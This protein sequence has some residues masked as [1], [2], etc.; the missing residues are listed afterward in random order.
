MT[1]N[2]KKDLLNYITE[3]IPEEPSPDP[4]FTSVEQVPRSKWLPF[5]P[6]SWSEFRFEGA[7][8]SNTSDKMIFY[9]GYVEGGGTYSANSKGIIIITDSELNPIKTIY[10]YSSGTDLRP[11]YCMIQEEDGQFVAVDSTVLH[12]YGSTASKQAYYN[13]QRRFIMLNDI[14]I[15]VDNEY[16]VNLRTSYNFGSNYNNFICKDMYKNPS[17]S[18]YFMAGTSID[19]SSSNYSPRYTK[20]IDLKV[21]V[22]SSNEWSTSRTSTEYVYGG[23]YCYFDNNDN[24]QW[25]LLVSPNSWTDNT[26]RYWFGTNGSATNSW[27]IFTLNY[28]T[29]IDGEHLECQSVFINE[30]LVYFTTNNQLWGVSGRLDTKY[31]GLYEY[32]FSTGTLKEIYLKSLGNYDFS[33]LDLIQL[34]AVN[35]ELYIEH[36]DP[37]NTTEYHN[38]YYTV[39]RYEGEWNPTTVGVLVNYVMDRRTFY[40]SQTFNITK[41]YCLSTNPQTRGFPLIEVTDIYNIANYNGNQYDSY[42]SL[43][44]KYVDILAN[45]KIVFSRNLHNISTINNYTIASVE[46]PNTYLNNINLGPST[47][48]G[49]TGVPFLEDNTIFSKN[50]YETVYL[51]YINTINVKDNESVIQTIPGR[52]INSNINIGT[53]EN[54]NNSRCSKIRINYADNSVKTFNIGWISQ[55]YTHKYCEFTIN[56]DKEIKNLE[57]IS[58]D[59]ST[60]YITIQ[61]ELEVGKAYTFKQYLK[62]E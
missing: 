9:G 39:Q 32:N 43:K 16:Q 2:Y 5:L 45:D 52:Y 15:P 49:E 59:E 61:R 48:I 44:G 24:A 25:K 37:L 11:I 62:V 60:T 57:F 27:P 26:I 28:K 4:T 18:H 14:S 3:L 41:M 55:D 20:V 38:A 29:Y 10:K 13:G 33:Y 34:Y 31:I 21:N 23:S 54:Y 22:G 19:T 35:G 50:I 1:T 6:N 47:L 56:V 42:N 46:I 30:N 36:C 51:N 53:E 40:V 12:Y 7:I 58:N 8:K 17:S